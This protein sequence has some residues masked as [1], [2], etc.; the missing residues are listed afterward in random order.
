MMGRPHRARRTAGALAPLVVSIFALAIAA[1]ASAQVSQRLLCD[2]GIPCHELAIDFKLPSGRSASLSLRFERATGLS[3]GSFKVSAQEVQPGDGALAGRLPAGVFV[4]P[5]LPLLFT[6]APNPGAGTKFRGMWRLELRTDAVEFE[7][8]TPTARLF[9]ARAGGG[10]RDA[11]EG[12]GQGSYHVRSVGGDFSEFLLVNDLRPPRRIA[13]IAYQQ[14]EGDLDA[15]IAANQID[16]TSAGVV[17]DR[18]QRSRAAFDKNDRQSAVTLLDELVQEVIDRSGTGIFDLYDPSVGKISQAGVL[19]S[20]AAGARVS[21]EL[22]SRPKSQAKASLVRALTTARGHRLDLTLDFPNE[23]GDL[24]GALAITA[25]DVDPNDAALL[26]RL[27]A[28]ARIPAAFPVLLKIAPTAAG[29][30]SFRGFWELS[31]HTRELEFLANS[32]LRLFKSTG[33]GELVDVTDTLGIGSYHVRGVGGDFSEFIIAADRRA[34]PQVTEDKLSRLEALLAGLASQITPAVHDDLT[35]LLAAARASIQEQH[36]S[37]AIA[38]LDD[39]LATVDGA[40]GVDV[41]DLFLQGDRASVAGQLIAGARSL[42]LSI[43]L[44]HNKHVVFAP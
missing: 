1:P 35:G 27:P 30:F 29:R 15:A 8:E 4:N 26:A 20:S 13:L 3:T 34:L 6:I 18:L 10:F 44:Q 33:G 38:T 11:T 17:R 2:P 31:L 12:V 28:G 36:F 5:R 40:S 42:Q 24:S 32:T 23:V 9:H 21:V 19:R 14:L 16:S 22:A 43:T 41:P 37:A 39:F 7:G 25:S